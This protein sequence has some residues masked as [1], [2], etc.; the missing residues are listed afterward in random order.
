MRFGIAIAILHSQLLLL[1][2][3]VAHF[4]FMRVKVGDYLKAM[5]ELETEERCMLVCNLAGCSK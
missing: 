5:I 1:F 3:P 2:H 4:D